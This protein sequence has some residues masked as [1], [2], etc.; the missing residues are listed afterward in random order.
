[1]LILDDIGEEQIKED[2]YTSE[3]LEFLVDELYNYEC[4]MMWTSN[5]TPDQMEAPT[6]YGY[7][8]VTRLTGLAPDAT[9]PHDLP[10]LRVRLRG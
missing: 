10:D 5:H 3:Q 9:L 8:L 4:R 2:S 7:R 1:M 6:Y